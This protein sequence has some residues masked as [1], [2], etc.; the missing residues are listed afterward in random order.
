MKIKIT[1]LEVKPIDKLAALS[2]IFSCHY[3][4]VMPRLTEVYL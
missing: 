2:L 4:K 3:S 1:Q